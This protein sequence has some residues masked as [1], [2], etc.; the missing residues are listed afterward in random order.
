MLQTFVYNFKLNTKDFEN[1]KFEDGPVE[2]FL[3]LGD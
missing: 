2:V 1:L 3:N